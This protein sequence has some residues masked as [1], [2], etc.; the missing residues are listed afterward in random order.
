MARKT[1]VRITA[2][3]SQD[4]DTRVVYTDHFSDDGHIWTLDMLQDAITIL[5]EKYDNLLTKD[6]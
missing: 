3:I 2:N 1:L 5:T 4:P 6:K